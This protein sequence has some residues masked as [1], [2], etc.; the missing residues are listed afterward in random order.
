MMFN[1]PPGWPL[2]RGWMPPPGWNPDPSWPPAPP[3]W[4]FWLSSD[5]LPSGQPP[6]GWQLAHF[7]LRPQSMTPVRIIWIVWCL[8]WVLVWLFWAFM[9]AVTVIGGFF[10]AVA[11]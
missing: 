11:A 9:L 1:P 4:N 7:A 6:V 5:A 2:P 3:G 8:I 10:C